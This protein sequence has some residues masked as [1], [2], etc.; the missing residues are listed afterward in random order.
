MKDFLKEGLKMGFHCEL[1]CRMKVGVGGLV[2]QLQE[3]TII[4]LLLGTMMLDSA[5]S[6]IAF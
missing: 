1:L 3:C 2:D 4:T 6:F 5:V